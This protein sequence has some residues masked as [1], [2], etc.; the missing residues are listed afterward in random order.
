MWACVRDDSRD[1]STCWPPRLQVWQ[2]L[3]ELLLFLLPLLDVTQLRRRLLTYLPRISGTGAAGEAAA[4]H[5]TGW[6]QA[7]ARRCMA[8]TF[9]LTP[10]ACVQAATQR[11]R[12]VPPTRR[13]A[14]AR[15]RPCRSHMLRSPAATCFATTACAAALRRTCSSCAHCAAS[16]WQLSGLPSD[17]SARVQCW[18]SDLV[19][20][21]RMVWQ[22]SL[23]YTV[24]CMSCQC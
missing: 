18:C 4:V 3:G 6:H 17:Q 19:L 20:W 22:D 24:D 23:L 16:A 7:Y 12:V 13:A 8:S 15:L 11:Q 2:G 10:V 14:C 21:S 1:L 5:D 9:V